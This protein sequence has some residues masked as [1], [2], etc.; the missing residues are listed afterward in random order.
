MQSNLI[1]LICCSNKLR[2]M[3]SSCI[4]SFNWFTAVGR[5]T[6]QINIYWQ[7]LEGSFCHSE[8]KQSQLTCSIFFKFIWGTMDPDHLERKLTIHREITVCV[9]IS[10]C[11]WFPKKKIHWKPYT[12]MYIDL[13]SPGISE[14]PLCFIVVRHAFAVPSATNHCCRSAGVAALR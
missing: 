6:W 2:Y 10:R 9:C 1:V 12:Y 7:Y 4:F 5:K 11:K 14:W 13:H 3:L 8:S